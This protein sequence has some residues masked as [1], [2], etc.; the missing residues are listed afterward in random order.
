MNTRYVTYAV[1]LLAVLILVSNVFFIVP[2]TSQAIVVQFGRIVRVISGP[3]LYARVPFIQSVSYFDRRILGFDAQ[4]AEFITHDPAAGIDERVVIDAFVRYRITDPVKFY[5]A[6]KTEGNADSRMGSIVLSAMRRVLGGRS[7]SDLLSAGREP[8]M[9]RIKGEVNDVAKGEK[10]TAQ[11]SPAFGIEVV[12]VRIMR[13][14]LPADISQ[15]T[16]ER[17][18]KNFTKEAQLFRAEGDEQ[19]TE[20]RASADR[21]KIEILSEA[22]KQS[23]TIRGEGDGEAAQIYA[24]AFGKDP[25]F[26]RFYRSMQAYR[27]TLSK[28]DT[29]M[30]LTPDSGFLKEMNQ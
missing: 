26:Y 9:E 13:A 3:G 23:E 20:T 2:Q 6:F 21:E 4:P 1:A 29:T 17:M 15:S 11:N 5:Q 14:D 19:A 7:L 16:Y 27:R 8:I 24:A 30:V 12:D 22:R 10:S 28:D 25:D 18:R